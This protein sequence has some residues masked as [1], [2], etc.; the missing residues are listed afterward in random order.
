MPKSRVAIIGLGQVGGSIGL[1]LKKANLEIEIVGHDKDPGVSGK[2]QKRGAVDSTKWNLIDACDGAGLIIL[3]LPLDGIRATLDALKPHLVPGTLITDTATTKVPV[4]E[5][6]TSLP[7]GVHF[8]GGNPVI[9]PSRVTTEHGIE[10]ASADFF[11]EATYCLVAAPA[12]SGEA[13]DTMANWASALGAKPYFID[14]AEHDG[15]M[16]GVQHLPTLLAATL[17][18]VT[19]QSTGWRELAKL[20]SSDFRT[21]TEIVPV[22]DKSAREQVL[23]HRDDI[24]RW[25]DLV[26]DRLQSVREM[27]EKQDAAGLEAMFKTIAVER[28]KWLAGAV[29]EKSQ[30]DWDSTKMSP[31]RLFLGGLADAGKKKR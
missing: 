17:A 4:L 7:V 28:A 24:L 19:M 31:A 16:A 10:G 12:A 23:A 3:A 29:E 11:Q 15:L 2:A 25:M 13:I 5:W 21:A 27:L 26:A 20:A 6:A 9:K 22:D 8:V 30:V 1:A 18:S 14:A